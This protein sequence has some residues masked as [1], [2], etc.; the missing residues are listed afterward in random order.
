M[1]DGNT[2]RIELYIHV[3]SGSYGSGFTVARVDSFSQGNFLTTDSVQNVTWSTTST[4]RSVFETAQLQNQR[5]LTENVHGQ[6]E[7]G[8][9][10]FA[11]ARVSFLSGE[12]FLFQ[13]RDILWTRTIPLPLALVL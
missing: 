3:Q 13:A 7:W 4:F 9:I 6:A 2:H 1:V 12:P 5:L 10:Y 8:Q 11:T